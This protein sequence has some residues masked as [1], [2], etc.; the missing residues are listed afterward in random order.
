M[1]YMADSKWK[2]FEYEY[3]IAEFV[4]SFVI[5]FLLSFLFLVSLYPTLNLY[6]ILTVS[7]VVALVLG[8]IWTYIRA[9]SAFSLSVKG[10]Q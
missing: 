9:S 3:S 4:L 10:K 7:G 8:L 2:L 6:E 1:K 5:V